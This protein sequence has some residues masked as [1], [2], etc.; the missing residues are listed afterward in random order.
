MV[1]LILKHGCCNVITIVSTVSEQA[2]V[3]L[4]LGPRIGGCILHAHPCEMLA[5]DSVA[6]VRT[7]PSPQ[8]FENLTWQLHSDK[9]VLKTKLFPSPTPAPAAAQDTL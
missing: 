9:S 3:V 2:S 5:H 7:A 6:E 4:L 8:G 1:N